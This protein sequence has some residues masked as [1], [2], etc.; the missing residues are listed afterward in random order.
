LPCWLI[1]AFGHRLCGLANDV[2]GLRIQLE[3]VRRFEKAGRQH[4]FRGSLATAANGIPERIELAHARTEPK[5]SALA[6][7][8]TDERP[9]LDAVSLARVYSPSLLANNPLAFGGI[10]QRNTYMIGIDSNTWLVYEGVSNYGHGV[11]PTPVVSIATLITGDTDWEKLPSSPHLD[12]AKLVFREDSFDPVTRIRRGR[13]YQWGDGCLQQTWYFTPHP[14]EPMDRDHMTMDGRLNR[15]LWTYRPAQSF[16]SLFPNILRA[17]LVL[18]TKSAP[19]VWQVVSVETVA[20][21]EE[22][23]TLRA[24]SS[25]GALPELIEEDIPEGAK[26]EVLATLAHVADGAFRSS[27]VSLVDLCRAA[28]TVV[29]AHWLES[30]G[31]APDNVHFLDLGALL[32]AFEKQQGNPDTNSPSAAG[33][34]I[35]LLQRFHSRGK[36]NEQKRYNTRPPT[37]ED[38]QLVLGALGFLLREVGWA[39]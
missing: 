28:T 31:D 14:A 13:L 1:S 26:T 34:A 15:T 27:P 7:N 4:F 21:G 33:S 38:A 29:L 11:W 20:S 17:Q 39:R 23:L 5:P 6:N 9:F 22:L 12:K 10:R 3:H 24:R 32:K 25:F 16:S 18:G 19:T 30:T 2:T 37:E 36:P 35:R 8:M